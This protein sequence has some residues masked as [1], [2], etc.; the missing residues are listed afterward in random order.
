MLAAFDRKKILIVEDDDFLREM[1]KSKLEMENLHVIAKTD[2]AQ[3]LRALEKFEPD[4][5]LLDII[6]PKVDGF[7]VLAKIRKDKKYKKFRKTPIIILTNLSTREAV[8]KAFALG[9]NDYL[10]K[11]HFI[12]SEVMKKVQ[13]YIS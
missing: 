5:I 2:G 4:L 3:G 9:A 6:M 7:E 8:D 13:K 10:I 12:P 1:Y 11:T